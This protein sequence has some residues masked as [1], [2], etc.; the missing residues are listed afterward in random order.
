[1][2]D[3]LYILIFLVILAAIAML[4]SRKPIA[5][6]GRG[7][8]PDDRGWKYGDEW[9]EGSPEDV[10]HEDK[11]SY[12]EILR[13][14]MGKGYDDTYMM[15]LV[16]YLGSRG[17]RATYDSFSLGIEGAA[18]KTYVLKVEAGKEEEARGYLK[19]DKASD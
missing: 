16:V 14:D 6:E 10:A 7:K 19:A 11:I 18:I 4:I 2:S 3:L 9:K 12:V 1:M 13:S 15:D 17:I 5:P 8:E